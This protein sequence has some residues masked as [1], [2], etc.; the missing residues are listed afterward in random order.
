[1][2]CVSALATVWRLYIDCGEHQPDGDLVGEVVRAAGQRSPSSA[3]SVGEVAH[4]PLRP[5]GSGAARRGRPRPCR[6][7]A[8]QRLGGGAQ[9]SSTPGS[10]VTPPSVGHDRDLA[11][12]RGRAC[13]GRASQPPGRGR[14]VRV[15]GVVAGADV[16]V[17][18]R[19]A[20]RPGQAAEHDGAGAEVGVAGHAGCG[21]RCPSSRAARCSRPGCGSSRRRR[22]RSRW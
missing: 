10:S 2:R 11:C 3:S 15:A 20:H 6:W 12:P 4:R 5:P 1:M 21:R 9:R 8:M 19:V 14:L 16:V 7:P 13:R 22:P 17:A 18:G